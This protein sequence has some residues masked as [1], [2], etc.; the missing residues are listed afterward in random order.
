[1]AW[2]PTTF[3][4]RWPEYGPTSDALITSAITDAGVRV[5]A[6]LFGDETDAAVGLLAA[7]LLAISPQ[8]AG[9]N[10]MATGDKADDQDG[11]STYNAE[12][13]RI[14]RRKAGG[15]WLAG[16]ATSGWNGVR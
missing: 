15:P 6:R 1:M 8:G 14:A 11:D 2:T 4:A 9:M 16:Q 3:R 10:R 13:K 12:F 7:H 5:D